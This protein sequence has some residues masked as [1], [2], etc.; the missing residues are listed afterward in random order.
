MAPS[1][2]SSRLITPAA[3]PEMTAAIVA[4]I[5]R[6]RRATAP[7]LLGAQEDRDP[8]QRAAILEGVLR[9]QETDAR[10]PWI[11]P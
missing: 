7:R 1:R 3:S 10:D 9:E 2:S 6:F 5:E 8:W 11:N 4:A